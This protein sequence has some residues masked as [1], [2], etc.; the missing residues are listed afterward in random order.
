M[1]WIDWHDRK[2]QEYS[3][4]CFDGSFTANGRS[5]TLDGLDLHDPMHPERLLQ[6]RASI[7][8]ASKHFLA[9]STIAE[10]IAFGV[11]KS[12]INLDRVRQA[13]EK[14]QISGLAESTSEGYDTFVGEQGVRLS[15]GQRQRIGIARALYKEASI[16]VLDEATSALDSRT[17]K[18]VIESIEGLDKDINIIIIAHRIS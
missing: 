18:D 14:A 3:S 4:R 2:W 1:C 5:N 9:D 17:E 7:A 6:W 13:A 8:H 12:R 10:N 11:P 15:G 16:I